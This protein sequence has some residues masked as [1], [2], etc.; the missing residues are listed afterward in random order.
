MRGLMVLLGCREEEKPAGKVFLS[1]RYY[2]HSDKDD[3]ITDLRT[4]VGPPRMH[5]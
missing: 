5:A 3:A 1:L 2:P 4:R